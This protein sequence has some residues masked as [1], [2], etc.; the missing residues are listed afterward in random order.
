MEQIKN[1]AQNEINKVKS[2]CENTVKKV[3]GSFVSQIKKV[4]EAMTL[5]HKTEVKNKI[6]KLNETHENILSD[7]VIRQEKYWSDIMEQNR[8]K[9]S[10]N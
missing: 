4:V 8:K 1:N 5:A 2:N 3:N 10:K 9:K 7:R 6:N